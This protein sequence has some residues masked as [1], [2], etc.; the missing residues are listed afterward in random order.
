MELKCRREQTYHASVGTIRP[1]VSVV[2]V[3]LTTIAFSSCGPREV[4]EEPFEP[5][6]SHQDYREGLVAMEMAE[7][8]IGSRWIREADRALT[9]PFPVSI[10]YQEI[11]HFD[12]ARPSAVGFHFSALRGQRIEITLELESG[13]AGRMFADLFRAGS[14]APEAFPQVASYSESLNTLAFEPRR[15]GEYIVRLQPELLRGGRFTVT[16]QRVP[17]LSFPVEG[18]GMDDIW[19]V[20]GD[21]RDGGARQH[22]GV[23]IFAPRGTPVLAVTGGVVRGVG[24]RDLGGRTVSIVDEERGLVYYY[25]HL[26]EQLTARGTVVEAGDVIGTVGNSGNA[27]TTPPHLHFGIYERRWNA[28][29]PWNFL[30]PHDTVPPEI[31]ADER[32]VGRPAEIARDM[33]E[34]AGAGPETRPVSIGP[35]YS[36]VVQGARGNE[37][38]VLVEDLG[39][40]GYV[41]Q[42]A[43]ARVPGS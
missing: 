38:R 35:E 22:E 37:Y 40:E 3:V 15:D 21:S 12:P 25:A 17:S 2:F 27:V 9:Q 43:L 10:P 39:A 16:I 4:V 42:S 26:E 23:D 14:G 18:H 32:L 1:T 30:F 6:S 13:E 8:A 28:V 41:P 20:F 5:R 29:D 19:S 34:L 11:A 31:R 24:V 33:V 36:V 7:T